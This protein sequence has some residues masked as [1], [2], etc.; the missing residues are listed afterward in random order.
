MLKALKTPPVDI[1]NTFTCVLNLLCTVDPN[2][3][4]DKAGKLKTEKPW[5]T[6][7]SLMANPA[8]FMTTLLGFKDKIDAD[9]VPPNN[10]KA[11]RGAL[12]DP[13]FTPAIIRGKSSA[14]GGLC[15]WIINITA[16]YD[17]FV[18]VEPKKLAVKAANLRL[19]DANEKKAELDTLVAKLTAELKVL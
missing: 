18:S 12:A 2:V 16:Y 6:S 1:S 15:D 4:V 7:L 11:I 13:N 19:S 10:F 9:M 17:V 3:P 5:S 8:N 14:A